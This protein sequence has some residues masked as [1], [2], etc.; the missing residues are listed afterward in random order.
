M[1]GRLQCSQRDFARPKRIGEM[2]FPHRTGRGNGARHAGSPDRGDKG[3]S[4]K[5]SNSYWPPHA[6]GMDP[7]QVVRFKSH[8]FY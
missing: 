6:N 3:P 5:P 7:E 2:S 8:D 4:P 1:C